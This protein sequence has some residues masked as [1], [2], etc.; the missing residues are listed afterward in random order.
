MFNKMPMAAN[1][2]TR[3]DP[4]ALMKGRALPAK[5]STLNITAMLMKASK[6]IQMHMP[7]AKKRPSSSGARRAIVRPR[8]M[9]A[10]YNPIKT[11]AP[12]E[13]RFPHRRRQ[14]YYRWEVPAG[15]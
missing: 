3:F 5:G 7:A 6:A 10:A 4:P 12:Q 14:R 8:H 11:A 13:H 9:M 2:T 15:R 1:E